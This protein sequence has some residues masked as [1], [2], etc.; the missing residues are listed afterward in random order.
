[1]D[2]IAAGDSLSI[3]C[4]ALVYDFTAELNWY[5]DEVLVEENSSMYAILV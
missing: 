5:K 1:M 3:F 2:P 4:G